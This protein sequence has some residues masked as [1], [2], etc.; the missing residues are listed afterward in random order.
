MDVPNK[1]PNNSPSNQPSKDPRKSGGLSSALD[2]IEHTLYDPKK[3]QDD[4]AMH[5]T[6]DRIAKELPSSWGDT[7]AIITKAEVKENISLGA[8][9][10]MLSCIFLIA[11]LGFTA[12]RVLS[13]RN[14]VS[15]ANI[16][17]TLG[18]APYIEG[19]E[20]TPLT[21][22]ITNRNQVALEQAS[23]TLMYKQGNGAQ[24]E[25]EKVNE[26][27]DIGTLITQA[28]LQQDFT[29]S[30][31]GSEA[32]SRDITVKFDY[33]VAGSNAVFSK[34]ATIPVI[35][36]TP[37]MTVS[38]DGPDTL[39]VGQSGMFAFTVKNNTST[40]SEQALLM[41]TLP[42][43][44]TIETASPKPSARSTVWSI[45]SLDPGEMHTITLT[46]NLTGA[47]GEVA[48]MRGL[49]GSQGTS[50]TDVGVVYASQTFDVK[51]R[52]TPLLLSVALATERGTAGNLRY[53]DVANISI[54][55]KNTST[56]PIK[57]VSLLVALTGD[58]ASLKDIEPD[59]G[60]YDSVKQ[61]I[62]W[63]SPTLPDQG[64][65]QPDQEQTVRIRIPI[66]L[67]GTNSPK[68]NLD[69]SGKGTLIETDDV[70]THATKSWAVQ[71]SAS[72]S[73]ETTYKNSPFQN[74]GPVPPVA[75][76]DTTYNTHI[77]LS[78]QN[79][80][81]NAKVSFSLPIY[82]S[83]RNITSDNAR[84]SYDP[85][86]RLVTWIPGQIEAGKTVTV[87]IGLSIRPSQSHVG[88]IPPITSGIIL[89]ATEDVSR[90]NIRTTISPLTT[91]ISKESWPT[92]PSRVVDR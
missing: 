3:K 34:V 64:V 27:K 15:S 68:L 10:L 24:D 22:T 30:I 13:S 51:L 21:V 69:I 76:Q 48:T 53:G 57:A 38:I 23:L 74:T 50:L 63:D 25:E 5:Q 61:S 73:A 72:I 84:V 33:K 8:K 79:A 19:G 41:L 11:A 65:I 26:K 17:M 49:I 31:Y 29:V 14:I 83:W 77:T 7:S 71:G 86:S 42:N 44:F 6:R 39:S 67:K 58:A 62:F 59:T 37:P 91:F 4:F 52:S 43:I 45:P 60:Y 56:Q 2:R 12:W 20:P 75:N 54:T 46:G 88:Q 78:A 89:D 18:I 55:Y 47:Q 81:S 80:L 28:S 9:L 70:V 36:K 16:D 82:T 1:E 92:N 40:T 87:D 66:V 32:E 90:A 35:L 85:K